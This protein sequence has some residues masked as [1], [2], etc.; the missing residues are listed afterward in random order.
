MQQEAANEAVKAPSGDQNL[1][2]KKLLQDPAALASAL[3]DAE[4]MAVEEF[5]D[6]LSA[7]V[8][9]RVNALKR[10]QMASAEL[11]A[12][13]YR[14]RAKIVT[15]EYEPTDEECVPVVQELE[16]DVEEKMNLDTQ[17]EEAAE[18]ETDVKGIPEFWLTLLRNVDMI[19]EWIQSFTLIFHFSPNEFFTNQTLTKVYYL[20][21][22]LDPEDP[23]SFNG[24]DIISCKGC[25]IDWKPGHNVTVKLIKKKQKQRK[26]GATR[27]VTKEIKNESFFNF[28]DSANVY[29]GRLLDEVFDEDDV[30]EE[31]EYESDS[32]EEAVSGVQKV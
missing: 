8:R 16:K 14:K 2:D 32:D 27:F 23:L 24:P 5:V 25:K 9:R 21:C 1:P 10:L 7:P 19:A 13:F 17:S 15:G 30:D 3:Q 11:E 6:S 31:E 4:G 18:A 12:E 29:S 28:F 22:K 26:G 20:S